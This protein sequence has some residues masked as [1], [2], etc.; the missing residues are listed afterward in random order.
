MKLKKYFI[1]TIAAVF[2]YNTFA[3]EIILPAAPTAAEKTAKAEIENYLK[4]AAAPFTIFGK[5]AKIY[6]GDSAV[7]AENKI[8][9][10]DMAE[11]A[12]VIK[13]VKP[14]ILILAGGGTRGTLYAVYHFLE[15]Y[16][17]IRW[18]NP[19]DEYVP[20]A[21]PINLQTVNDSGKPEIMIRD[22]YRNPK[23]PDDK[24]RWCARNRVNIDGEGRISKEYGGD[25][26]YGL[27]YHTHTISRND[28]YLPPDKYF[29]AHPEYYALVK[30]KREAAMFKG[31]P[32]F[33]HPDLPGIFI[34]RLKEF[35][36]VDEANAKKRGENPP[37]LYDLSINDNT[38]WCECERCT[39]ALKT[40]KKSDLYVAFANKIADFLAKY[41]PGYYLQIAAYFTTLEP[42]VKTIPADNLM[43]R[44]TYTH[45]P[46]H[47]SVNS[48]E[49]KNFRDI[50]L[51]WR[52]IAKHLSIWEYGIT[53]DDSAGLPFPNEWV[54]ADNKRFYRDCKVMNILIEHEHPEV[55]DMWDMKIWLEAKLQ[56]NP[57]LDIM[58]L[59]N[60]FISKYYGPAAPQIMKYRQTLRKWAIKNNSQVA[61]FSPDRKAF[62]YIDYPA[63]TEMQKIFDEA[64]N[65]VKNQEVYL[66]RVRRARFALDLC[67]GYTLRHHLRRSALKHKA[68]LAK[69]TKLCDDA[70]VR[71]DAT[72]QLNRKR[73]LRTGRTPHFWQEKMTI[74]Q[75]FEKLVRGKAIDKKQQSTGPA[76][77]L[78]I[79]K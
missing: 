14:D 41:R 18:W 25:F 63:I 8:I 32:C 70:L 12:W 11:E 52:K 59:M 17:G 2:F 19:F 68:D 76:A 31:Q 13:T 69:F 37:R 74:E 42:P 55:A 15:K 54:I 16:I 47:Y 46:R 20:A 72:Y 23:Y 45:G 29:A 61:Y 43:I 10:A 4:K 28:G 77:N 33:T 75:M 21:G 40:L 39:D 57:D 35:I 44:V 65:M 56:E 7:A 53:F 1:G 67:Q 48:E 66:V 3:F 24:G 6:I 34:N 62:R 36:A 49:N 64:E 58:V 60:D 22:I 30:G 51:K 5:K 9:C 27:P 78:Q 79:G 50:L 73:F 26:Y 38:A 71:A